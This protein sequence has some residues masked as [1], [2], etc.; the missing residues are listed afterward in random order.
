M[1]VEKL[2]LSEHSGLYPCAVA[3]SSQPPTAQPEQAPLPEASAPQV[4]AQDVQSGQKQPAASYLPRAE[5]ADN[6]LIQAME[7]AREKIQA[8]RDKLKKLKKTNINYGNAPMEA[9]SRLARARTTAQ[10]G[11]AAGYARRRLAQLQVAKGQDKDNARQIQSA[12]NQLRKAVARA[13]K[14]KVELQ[15]EQIDETR[16]K[17]LLKQQQIRKAKRLREQLIRRRTQRSIRESGYFQEVEVENCLQAMLS[18]TEMDL[19]EQAQSL[20]SAYPGM[21]SVDIGRQQYMV[22]AA[23]L[24]STQSIPEISVTV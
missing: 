19:R 23:A 11:A 10:A 6:G 9:Y 21:C 5:D 2:D 20:S 3:P 1:V 4:P 18:K 24:E 16:K 13:G 14:K 7:E 15:K 22:Q 8:H 12:I 17:K